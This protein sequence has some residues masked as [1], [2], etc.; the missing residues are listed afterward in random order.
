MYLITLP[1]TTLLK[2]RLSPAV[3]A[4]YECIAGRI[5]AENFLGCL[6]ARLFVLSVDCWQQTADRKFH[7]HN[8]TRRRTTVQCECED[9][10]GLCTNGNEDSVIAEGK[11]NI[12]V[13][14]QF[15]GLFVE[16]VAHLDPVQFR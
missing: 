10:L 6:L 7:L 12:G 13:A 14:N 3:D 15:A 8:W 4:E 11:P 16:L 1:L 9:V 5:G 2:L